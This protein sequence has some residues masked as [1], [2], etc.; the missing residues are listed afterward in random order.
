MLLTTNQGRAASL[1]EAMEQIEDLSTIATTTGN[2][3]AA[4]L[5]VDL[6]E[7]WTPQAIEIGGAVLDEWVEV[8]GL[9]TLRLEARQA[10]VEIRIAAMAA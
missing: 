8:L 3:W 2:G 7:E 9:A 1:C 4:G 6:A 5:A 10:V